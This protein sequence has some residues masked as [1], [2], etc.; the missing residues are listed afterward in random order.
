MMNFTQ[1]QHMKQTQKLVMTQQMRQSLNV[2]QMNCMELREF[3]NQEITQNPVLEFNENNEPVENEP[4][5]AESANDTDWES[6]FNQERSLVSSTF[7]QDAAEEDG[8]SFENFS[9][10]GMTLHEYLLLQLNMRDYGL[11]EKET[12]LAK[13]MIEAVDDDGYCSLDTAALSGAHGEHKES[14]ERVLAVLHSFDPAGVGARDIGECLAIQL[15]Q[16]GLLTKQ[17]EM[18]L[19]EYLFEIANNEFDLVAKKTGISRA[20]LIHFKMQLKELNPRPG[21]AFDRNEPLE[22]VVPDATIDLIDGELLVHINK[23]SAPHLHIS[24][25][26]KKL[27]TS[28]EPLEASTREYLKQNFDK[29]E[30]L[31]KNIQSRRET[32]Y[33]IISFIAKYQQD[34]FTGREK[35]SKAMSLRLIADEI[36]MHESTV[37]RAVKGK[38]IQTPKGIFEIRSFL[39]HGYAHNGEQ[40]SS[41]SIKEKIAELIASENRA[42]P[43]SDQKISEILQQSD[44]KIARR[45][46]AKYREELGL[47]AASKRKL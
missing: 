3:I 45:T 18:L 16:N 34:Y 19:Q 29:A 14:V 36:N 43:L 12:T 15:R 47:S 27:Y 24:D 25:Y 32:V 23:I 33:K 39:S 13:Y 40:V 9:H 42:K 8:Y 44:L 35:H 41:N 26:Y 22:F 11:S 20:K 2:L 10:K 4:A 38:Y 17:F 5:S 31:V 46:V 21:S 6:Y 28:S 30:L 37:S 1:V 7:R